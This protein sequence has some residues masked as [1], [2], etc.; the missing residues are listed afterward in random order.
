V[1]VEEDDRFSRDG[2]DLVTVKD[3][4]APDA[5]LGTT[6]D[7]DTLDGTE[8]V[9]IEPGT[10]PF[11]EIVLRGKGMPS[12]RH[13]GRGDHRIVVNVVV[14]RRLSARQRELHEELRETIGE[15][16]LRGDDES[17]LSRVRRAFR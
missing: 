1:R 17:I 11:A 9:R 13:R 14:P 10:Q 12:L 2:D 5:A 8:Q 4:P 16:N 15:D 3:V 7:V 6:I